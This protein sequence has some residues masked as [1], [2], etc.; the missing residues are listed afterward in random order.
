M[1]FCYKAQCTWFADR[2]LCLWPI[3]PPGLEKNLCFSAPA[4][5]EVGLCL[6]SRY[7]KQKCVMMMMM[8]I[9]QGLWLNSDKLRVM[10]LHS[11]RDIF[12]FYSKTSEHFNPQRAVANLWRDLD[13]GLP[14]CVRPP[15]ALA[16][17]G[18]VHY[19]GEGTLPGKCCSTHCSGWGELQNDLLNLSW[20]HSF[21]GFK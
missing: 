3:S 16:L 21:L 11:E 17:T 13:V 9:T 2:G 19:T 15:A 12:V 5:D 10:R 6:G 14:A 8:M 1:P 18:M 7:W 4:P 20:Q